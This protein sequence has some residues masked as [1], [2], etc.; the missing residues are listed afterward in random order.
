MK[1]IVKKK[2]TEGQAEKADRLSGV[3]NP[4]V[5]AFAGQLMQWRKEKGLS[6]RHIASEL[7]LSISIVCEWEH[8]RRFPSVDHLQALALYMGVPAWSLLR[9]SGAAKKQGSAKLR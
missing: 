5:R 3:R 7:D 4:L 6:L 1:K 9:E 2:K 8:G